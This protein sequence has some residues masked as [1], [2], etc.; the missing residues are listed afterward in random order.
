MNYFF[1]E[2][3]LKKCTSTKYIYIY[4]V[5]FKGEIPIHFYMVSLLLEGKGKSPPK[6]A[7]EKTGKGSLLH[8]TN[9]KDKWFI[10]CFNIPIK[11]PVD[12]VYLQI[13][14]P[15]EQKMEVFN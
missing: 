14:R 13:T 1:R 6:M 3:T 9:E 10:D 2:I 8:S 7:R 11:C 15:A 12:F 4:L 5:I